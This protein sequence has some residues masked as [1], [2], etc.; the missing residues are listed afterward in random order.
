MELCREQWYQ[1]ELYSGQFRPCLFMFPNCP[2]R[3]ISLINSKTKVCGKHWNKMS[4]WLGQ[5]IGAFG[6][7][8]PICVEPVYLRSLHLPL[9]KKLFETSLLEKPVL[10]NILRDGSCFSNIIWLPWVC[11]AEIAIRLSF[12]QTYHHDLFRQRALWWF[13]VPIVLIMDPH[14]YTLLPFKNN[15]KPEE[16]VLE[17]Q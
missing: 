15:C 13:S 7:V 16:K 17:E 1:V 10:L 12:I 11:T 9:W 14:Y 5:K 6:R 2:K 8:G 4:E 3:I